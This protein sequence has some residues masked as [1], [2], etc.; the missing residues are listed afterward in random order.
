MIM[1][2]FR[3]RNLVSEIGYYIKSSYI[4]LMVLVF[5]LN[6]KERERE[7]VCNQCWKFWY[8]IKICYFRMNLFFWV[9][10]RSIFSNISLEKRSGSYRARKYHDIS[11]DMDAE[12]ETRGELSINRTM[13]ISIF[14]SFVASSLFFIRLLTCACLSI[15]RFSILF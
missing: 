14:I 8:D 11:S 2:I 13:G 5:S 12:S 9:I 3:S 15:R 6:V 7:R 4:K 10:S 1:L